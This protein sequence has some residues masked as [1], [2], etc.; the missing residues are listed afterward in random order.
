M[1][2]RYTREGDVRELLARDRRSVR[3]LP[4]GDEIALSF[5]ATALPALPDGARRTFLL[6]SGGFS[7][8]MDIHSASPDDAAPLPFHGMT[9][10][11]YRR[12]RALSARDDVERF[13]TRV[14]TQVD[15]TRVSV[16]RAAAA[17]AAE[18]ASARR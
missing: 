1:P 7:K 12:R 6:H 10:Y 13:H 9:R 17:R 4:P 8:E 2:G 5:D 18:A 15:T 16:R 11:P 3:R 14:V